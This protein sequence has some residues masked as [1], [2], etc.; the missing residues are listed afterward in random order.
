M[1]EATA[2]LQKA[3]AELVPDIARAV[4]ERLN[5]PK[6]YTIKE[7]AAITHRSDSTVRADIATGKLRVTHDFHAPGGAPGR[8]YRIDQAELERYL[9]S[10]R[11]AGDRAGTHALSGN[12]LSKAG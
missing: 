5:Q 6:L 2:D 9:D 1:S 4:V 10:A 11:V 3:L 12:S 8:S 7:V